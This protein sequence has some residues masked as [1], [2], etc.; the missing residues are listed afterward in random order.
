MS[1]RAGGAEE[2]EVPSWLAGALSPDQAYLLEGEAGP[3]GYVLS[4]ADQGLIDQ[5]EI[6]FVTGGEGWSWTKGPGTVTFWNTGGSPGAVAALDLSGTG[7]RTAKMQWPGNRLYED[8]MHWYTVTRC[9]GDHFFQGYRDGVCPL[10]KHQRLYSAELPDP[11]GQIL[12][13]KMGEVPSGSGEN[14]EKLY[15]HEETFTA[16]YTIEGIKRDHETGRPLEGALFQVLESFPDRNLVKEEEGDGV[17]CREN[18][19]PSPAVWEG[20][21]QCGS[22]VTDKNGR[23]SHTD[24]RTYDY[25][26]TYC[27]GHPTPGF[28]RIPE[29]DR[30]PE[31]GEVTNQGEIDRARAANG[32]MAAAW[33]QALD[34]CREREE[35][36]Q[37]KHFHWMIDSG[38]EAAVRGTKDTGEPCRAVGA[39]SVE[40]AFEKSGCREDCENSY[41]AFINLRYSYTLK[42][43]TA[44]SGYTVHGAHGDDVPV[45]VITTDSSEAGANESFAGIY[46]GDVS[47]VGDGGNFYRKDDAGQEMGASVSDG[48]SPLRRGSGIFQG[49]DDFTFCRPK[50]ADGPVPAGDE[51]FR[52]GRQRRGGGRDF[53]GHSFGAG[54]GA[55]PGHKV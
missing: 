44:R 7:Y 8:Y 25:S 9:G 50:P 37:G 15:R 45:E 22:L 39:V 55:A 1:G 27:G 35:E 5:A 20:F 43:E 3:A 38:A 30:D 18:C 33:L 16:H 49:G 36:N 2:K 41:E 17:L 6:S 11:G 21:R 47:A 34:D 46:S 13:V 48:I 40:T 32:V 4:V 24:I 23:M 52:G 42:E 19:S 51:N 29:K 12:Y 14:G 26:K 28:L 31:T 53:D 10:E 54:D